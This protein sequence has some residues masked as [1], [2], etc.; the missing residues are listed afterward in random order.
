MTTV[1]II[2][3]AQAQGNVDKVFQGHYDG[4]IT[5]LGYQQLDSLAEFCKQLK[6]DK[7]Y[8]SPLFRAQETAKA[9]NRYYG[10]EIQLHNGLMEIHGGDWEGQ[11]WAD[12]PEK[13]PV[14]NDNWYHHPSR[15]CAPNGEPMTQVYERVKQTLLQLV[16]DN[17]NK[18]IAIISHGCAISNLLAFIKYRCVDKLN[19]SDIVDNASVTKAVFDGDYFELV[20]QNR[21]DYLTEELR[22]TVHQL[23]N[24]K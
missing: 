12:F 16:A 6:L 21:A 4:E 19:R 1:Y 13:D 20:W 17:P 8:S 22:T 2:R 3:H 15:F 24:L 14:Q 18:T 7:I 9:V 11:K 5:Q 10:H 23:W